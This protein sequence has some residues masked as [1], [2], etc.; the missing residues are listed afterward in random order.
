MFDNNDLAT[1]KILGCLYGGAA[2]DALGYAVEF[3]SLDEI[4]GKYGPGGIRYYE[5]VDGEALFSD[6][7]QMLL[8]TLEGICM[9][10]EIRK[11]NPGVKLRNCL[12]SAY[13]DWIF[14][15][16][17]PGSRKEQHKVHTKLYL[18]PKMH[19]RRGPGF[20][21][22]RALRSNKKGS[23]LTPCNDSKGNGGVMRVAPVGFSLPRSSWALK[24]VI[25]MGAESAALTHGHPLGYISSGLMVALINECVYGSSASLKQAIL[26]SVDAT[27]EV[28]GSYPDTA[29]LRRLIHA[30][31]ALS[32]T[33][34]D[35]VEAIAQL[36]HSA[37]AESTMAIAVYCALKY[38]ESF[39]DAI[40][41]AVNFNGDSDTVA[42]VAGNILGAWH[43]IGFIDEKW[44]S[45][46]HLE[47]YLSALNVYQ[48]QS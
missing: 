6:D 42:A 9:W 34:T 22:I 21:C 35:D 7:T 30:A 3:M 31:I 5:L 43:G 2:G 46:L 18:N 26:L 44:I 1:Q 27:A 47:D 39:D 38:S 36:G 8:F 14:T 32:E 25:L 19:C 28:F 48:Q 29:E 33:Q 12:Y 10:E 15:Q 37:C 45:P 40:I 17:N 4:R 16:E 20:T 24:D 23:L 13:H 11:S 41:A